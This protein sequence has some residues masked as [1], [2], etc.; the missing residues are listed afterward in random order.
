M[1]PG[2]STSS[3]QRGSLD[4]LRALD[5]MDVVEVLS[6][7][8]PAGSLGKGGACRSWAA[9]RPRWLAR[10]CPLPEASRVVGAAWSCTLAARRP[11]RPAGC[12]HGLATSDRRRC[13]RAAAEAFGVEETL[14]VF[15][16]VVR[17]SACRARASRRPRWSD[18]HG[19]RW[20]ARATRRSFRPGW[21]RPGELAARDPGLPSP[22]R[23]PGA[24]CCC[25]PGRPRRLRCSGY[26][27]PY[28]SAGVRAIR[29]V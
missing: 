12:W 16:E 26:P 9:G 14:L 4:A 21:G 22:S 5:G 3:T 11:R 18:E 15:G 1:R 7:R 2:A 6:R 20:P 29:E 27:W 24:R 8:R 17:A 28:D 25:R 19:T 23:G 13:R 10:S